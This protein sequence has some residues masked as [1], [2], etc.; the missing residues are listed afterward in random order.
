MELGRLWIATERGKLSGFLLFLLF[1]ES[2]AKN[3][4]R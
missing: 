3:S 2:D 1:K 4:G